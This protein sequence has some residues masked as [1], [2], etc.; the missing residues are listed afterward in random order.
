VPASS[1]GLKFTGRWERHYTGA[2]S[3]DEAATVNSDSQVQFNFVGR[4]LTGLFDVST[5]TVAPELWISFDGGPETLVTVNA[6]ELDLTPPGTRTGVHAVRISVKDTDQV[7]NRWLLPLN[8]AVILRGLRLEGGGR[9]LT[10]PARASVR[11]AFYGD[12]ITEGV[13]ALGD[14]LTPDGADGTRTYANVTARALH[15]DIALVGFGKQGVM[16]VGVGNVP[17]AP[18][19]FPYNFQGSP[20]DPSFEPNIVVLLEG[21][22]DST[23]TDEEFAP[24]YSNYLA[25]ARAS[26]PHAWIFAME[27]LI[28]RHDPVIKSDVAKTGDSKIVYVNTDGWLDR[29][30]TADY[31]DTVHPTVAGHLKVASHLAPIIS[32]TTGLQLLSSP[33]RI[34]V[35]DVAVTPA[36]Q[37]TVTA[38]V[39]LEQVLPNTRN[40]TRGTVLVTPPD[41]FTVDASQRPFEIRDGATTT[42]QVKLRGTLPAGTTSVAGSVRVL[43]NDQTEVLPTPLVVTAA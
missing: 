23:V 37:V 13:R 11:M 21:S 28:G 35:P 25:E 43:V 22:N 39:N 30:S 32:E 29:H 41:G 1:S 9:L 17:T 5:V 14:P 31:T 6:P 42:V 33:V 12:S 36:Q 34:A 38:S 40:R 19:S 16:R 15:A 26:A 20:A 10:P 24:Y 4:R 8:D 7:T 18:E 3:S 27:P 2:Y